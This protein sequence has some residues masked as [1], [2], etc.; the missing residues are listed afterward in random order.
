MA[1]PKKMYYEMLEST[2]PTYKEFTTI[3][4]CDNGEP[5]VP[6]GSEFEGS[7]QILEN[8]KQYTGNQIFVRSHVVMM[9][10]QAQKEL[11]EIYP[12]YNLEVICGYRHP[13][14]QEK[15]HSEHKKWLKEQNPLLEGD[16]LT[17]VAHRF[18]AAPDVAGHPTGGAVDVRIIGSEGSPVNMGPEFEPSKDIYVFSPFVEK[19][20]WH[21]RQIL[22]NCMVK[23]GFA[24]FDGEWWHF[25]YGDREWAN[26]YNKPEAIYAQL[27]FQI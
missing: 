26:Y 8:Y 21:I 5:L 10:I 27:N 25:A 9:L 20:V 11:R 14:I 1:D 3:P 23:A 12:D 2:F 13:E 6:I 4:V 7:L 18:S 19:E 15:T 17:E 16:E 24:P 22:R